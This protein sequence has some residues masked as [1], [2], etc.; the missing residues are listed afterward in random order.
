MAESTPRSYTAEEKKRYEQGVADYEA[1]LKA[2]EKAYSV[3]LRRR[4]AVYKKF[5]IED[6][7]IALQKAK[8]ILDAESKLIDERQKREIAAAKQQLH[9][10]LSLVTKK[11]K[12]ADIQRQKIR[13]EYERKIDEITSRHEQMRAKEQAKYAAVETEHV[14]AVLEAQKKIAEVSALYVQNMQR[15]VSIQDALKRNSDDIADADKA[16]LEALS[17]LI[18]LTERAAEYAESQML[19]IRDR[20]AMLSEELAVLQERQITLSVDDD[21]WLD[22]QQAI[23][24]VSKE[25][26]GLKDKS[27]TAFITEFVN[28]AKSEAANSLTDLINSVKE[29]SDVR[30]FGAFKGTVVPIKSGN[31]ERQDIANKAERTFDVATYLEGMTADI[32]ED[33]KLLQTLMDA[34]AE[35]DESA[36]PEFF[37]AL[38]D[39][40]L[41]LTSTIDEKSSKMATTT[42]SDGGSKDVTELGKILSAQQASLKV[43]SKKDEL[44]KRRTDRAL[45]KEEEAYYKEGGGNAIDRKLRMIDKAEKSE[46][47]AKEH[48]AQIADHMEQAFRNALDDLSKSID[49]G[50]DSFFEY[51][52][53]IEGRLQGSG[54][55]YKDLLKTVSSKVAVS[56]FVSQKDVVANIKSLVETGVS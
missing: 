15:R 1:T 48:N 51:Q 18:N 11:D 26:D 46:Q 40:I 6:K 4:R 30:E 14:E 39:S 44:E 32:E 19:P 29:R 9:Q 43:E 20:I 22:V 27:E 37:A 41:A 17:G 13:E 3:S 33:K 47:A 31:S 21:E 24:G 45:K 49:N 54:E 12:A 42:D 8:E 35:T 10:E 50:I 7:T 38:N 56:P 55:S 53:S 23:E 16:H 2:E 28:E 34:R 5:N 52:A 36:D 25:L